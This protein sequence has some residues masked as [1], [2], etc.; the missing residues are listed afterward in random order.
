VSVAGTHRT[1]S[2]VAFAL[3]AAAGLL[4]SPPSFTKASVPRTAPGGAGVGW[5]P[6]VERLTAQVQPF[7]VHCA[8]LSPAARCISSQWPIARRA[9]P[10]AAR[11]EPTPRSG[12]PPVAALHAAGFGE[13]GTTVNPLVESKQLQPASARWETP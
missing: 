2:P 13:G 10:A 8:R 12:T 9:H 11:G 5:E 1:S 6:L 7:G 3:G 4:L